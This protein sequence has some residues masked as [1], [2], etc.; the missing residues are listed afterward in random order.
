MKCIL[1][2]RRTGPF[3]NVHLPAS[4]LIF[5]C[6]NGTQIYLCVCSLFT[7]VCDSKGMC[8]CD[9]VCVCVTCTTADGLLPALLEVK[10]FDGDWLAT[11]TGSI[12]DSSTAPLAQDITLL[13][14]TL[15]L[16]LL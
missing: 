9:R 12:D 1:D 3:Y 5:Y 13:L 6:K 16:G 4:F 2:H 8:V 11:V 14:T 7:R 10:A 15:Q